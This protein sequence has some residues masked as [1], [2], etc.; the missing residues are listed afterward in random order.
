MWIEASPADKGGEAFLAGHLAEA[1]GREEAAYSR[2]ILGRKE[3]GA[4]AHEIRN[5]SGLR[6]AA[7]D[8]H[9][10]EAVLHER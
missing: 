1:T 8:V 5:G 2:V 4:K 6:P 9:R 10:G 7:H 3:L